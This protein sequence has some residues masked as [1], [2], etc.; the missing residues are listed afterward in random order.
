MRMRQA[1]SGV[2]V[3]RKMSTHDSSASGAGLELDGPDHER[4][5]ER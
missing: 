1:G 4:W 2:A 5:E 3:R